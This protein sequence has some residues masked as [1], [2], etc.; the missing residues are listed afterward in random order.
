M[1]QYP[2]GV[3]AHSSYSSVPET[4]IVWALTSEVA[5]D[6]FY[7]GP[8]FRGTGALRAFAA[9]DVSRELWN[10][11][12][13]VSRDALGDLASFTTPLVA[14]GRVYVP[15]LTNQ[16][17]VYGLLN[18]PVPGDANGD[19]VVDCADLLLVSGAFGKT[20]GQ[21][22]FDPRADVVRDGVINIRDL[23]LVSRQL[24]AGTVCR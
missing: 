21:A 18:G 4:G 22:G 16:L 8:G 7:F 11:N 13:N 10:S 12:Q 3:L 9:S 6:G 15:T 19:S 24:R 5:D 17:V 1:A 2:G 20:A 14:N 23:S